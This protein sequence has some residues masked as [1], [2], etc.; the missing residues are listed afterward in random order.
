[1]NAFRYGLDTLSIGSA[2]DICQKRHDAVL[3]EE[4]IDR[5]KRCRAVVERV[6]DEGRVIY[7]VTTGFG[8]LCSTLI[9]PEDASTLQHNLLKSHAAGVGS[10]VEDT[11]VRL[12]LVLKIHSLAMGYSGIRLET[13]QRIIWHVEHDV[14]PLVPSQGSVGASGDLAPLAHLFLPLIGMGSLRYQGKEHPAGEL[15]DQ[16]GKQPLHLSAKEGLALINGTQFMAAYGIL[17][18]YR[19]QSCL[20]QADLIA[21][22]M[23]EALQGSIRPFTDELHEIRPHP[24]SIYVAQRMRTF[25]EQSEIMQSHIDCGRVQ[26]PYSLRCIPQVHG[27][28]R[29]V[30]AHVK[31]VL[32]IEI[33][34]VTDNPLIFADGS[35]VS[36]GNFHG[37]PI[38]LP[39]DYLATAAAEIG[40]ISDR[41]IYLAFEG[42][43]E[44]LPPLLMNDTGINSGFMIVQYTTAALVSENK[45]LCFPASVDSIPTSRGQE[46]HVSMGS[47]SGRKCLQVVKNLERILALEMMCAAQGLDFRR[48]LRSSRWIEAVHEVIRSHIDHRSKDDLFDGDIKTAVSMIKEGTLIKGIAKLTSDE[49]SGIKN[50]KH[51]VFGVY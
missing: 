6:I 5:V 49:V 20:D 22:T 42:K 27:A 40:N 31:E 33:N 44:G 3:E 19:L 35:I 28:S 37:Q 25:L 51:E 41:R 46:D 21:A 7:G 26:D 2:M 34:S 24:G 8:S 36:G 14:L 18:L 10:E 11:I 47:I 12:M 23:V 39:M 38:A 13:L 29:D 4:A 17:A 48:P 15:L 43:Y 45:A 30:Y 50:H 16:L 1:M 9:D 32:E